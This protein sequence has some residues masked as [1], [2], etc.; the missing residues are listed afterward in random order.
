MRPLYWTRIQ[1]PNIPS[2]GTAKDGVGTLWDDLEDIPLEVDE[3][4]DL[5]S[6]PVV[7]VNKGKKENLEVKKEEPAKVAVAKLLDPKR[8][9][10][11]GIFMKSNH[12]SI[13][14]VENTIYNF[15]NSVIDFETLG[16]IK[17]NQATPD[18]LS[19]ITA[20]ESSSPDIP[21]DAPEKFL[22]DLS[23][24]SHFNERLECFMFQTRFADS[25][26]DIEHK[27]NNIKHV[28]NMLMSSESMKQVFSVIVSCGNYM[29]G[30]N[31]QRGQ[32]D[33][34]AI[35]ILPKLNDVKSRD[36]TT[37][38]LQYVVRFCILKFDNKKGTTEAF[39]PVPEPS[40]VEKSGHINFDELM[41]E[42]KSLDYGLKKIQNLRD[43]VTN[44]QEAEH[45]EP[46]Q[47]KM[48]KCLQD[49]SGSLKDLEDLVNECSKKFKDTKKFFKF[50][51]KDAKLDQPKDFFTLWFSFCRDYKNLWKK[52][53]ARIAKEIIRE[54][55]MRHRLKTENLKDF[56]TQP[57]KPKGLKDRI[58]KRKSRNNH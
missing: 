4:D 50:T 15:D 27:L 41:N 21:L 55:R 51:P 43:K 16:Q 9:Q 11:I 6:R 39:M 35:D 23:K 40:D 45:L 10:N 36:N 3:F 37:T 7:K 19:C 26:S 54:E 8:S 5:F 1:V 28:C 29:N 14:E 20:H 31:T 58:N 34:F 33:G 22:L 49:A 52:E 42:S 18:E 32:A 57:T 24:I 12:L 38:L 2:D 44:D 48:T 53:Q 25:V 30:G 17:V 13:Q 46:F 56:K 47:S